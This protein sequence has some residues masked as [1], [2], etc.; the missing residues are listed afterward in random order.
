MT[1][2][3]MAR[4][5]YGAGSAAVRTTRGTEYAVFSQITRRIRDAA[6][7]GRAGFPALAAALHDNRRLWTAIAADVA[8]EGNGLPRDLRARLFALAEFTFRHTGQVLAGKAQVAPLIDVNAS[9]MRG[10]LAAGDAAPG[11]ARAAP[12]PPDERSGSPAKP[13]RA[14]SAPAREA[15]R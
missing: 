2:A 3:K 12:R 7:R 15:G 13:A 5:A 4:D 10:L 14:T 6:N 9:I 8:S 1:T 11:T